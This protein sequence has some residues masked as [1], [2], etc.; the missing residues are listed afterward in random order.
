[1]RSFKKIFLLILFPFIIGCATQVSDSISSSSY[2]TA[3]SDQ[4]I[5]TKK[6]DMDLDDL[7][8]FEFD[9][10]S[11]S[12]NSKELISKYIEFAKK[13]KAIRLEG[14]CDERGTREYNLAL[15]EKRAIEVK[16][17]LIIKGISSSKIKVISY[18]EEKPIDVE[19]S[20]SAWKKNRRVEIS[21]F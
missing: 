2:A 8:Y 4:Y 20:E 3:E 17:Y 15:G 16:N 18:G 10:A 5:S 14:H 12:P 6:L 19:S 9:K 1:M 21:L 7:I 11:L 13:A